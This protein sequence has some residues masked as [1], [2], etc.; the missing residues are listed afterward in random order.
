MTA[1][2]SD[3]A[4]NIIK[5][6][7]QNY[8]FT[9]AYMRSRDPTTN[10]LRD[11]KNQGYYPFTAL[12]IN[13]TNQNLWCLVRIASNIAKWILLGNGI[14]GPI[15]QVTVPNGITPIVPDT[16]GNVNFT[17]A[18][19]TVTITGSS[20][21]PNNHTINFDLSGGGSAIDQIAVD[22]FTAPGTNPVLP[23]VSGQITITGGQVATGVVGTNV[24]R[25]DS[26]AANTFTIEIQRSTAVAASDVTKNGVSHFDSADFTVGTNG[27]VSGNGHTVKWNIISVNQSPMVKNNGYIC[28]SPGGALTLSLPSTASST[29]GDLLEVTLDGA[30]SWQITQAAG[31]SIQYNNLTST[32]GVGGSITTTDRGNTIRIVYQSAGKWNILSALGTLTVT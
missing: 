14:S 3:A 26:L 5:Y 12:W 32:V 13:S 15:I 10:D 23:N 2:N 29:L 8:Q 7:G 30:T 11:P 28:I 19:G 4:R 16:L 9:P 6:T 24:L 22:T 20:A 31:Q 21:S 18:L 17:S 1:Q 25:T 27:F